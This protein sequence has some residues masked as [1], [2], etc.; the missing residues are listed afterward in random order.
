MNRPG[1]PYGN[2]ITRENE[3]NRKGEQT[4]MTDTTSAAENKPAEIEK[5]YSLKEIEGILQVTHRSLLRYVYSGKLPARKIA[6]RYRVTESD[7][8]AFLNGEAP[9]G[10]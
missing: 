2:R 4:P 10:K 3:Q 1:T 7:L 6:G 8:R 9:A 5:L